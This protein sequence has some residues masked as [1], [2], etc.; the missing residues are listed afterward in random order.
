MKKLQ[1]IQFSEGFS[2]YL[3]IKINTKIIKKN[4]WHKKFMNF[5]VYFE[6]FIVLLN[7]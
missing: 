3:Y 5:L 1:N 7:N 4:K 2:I 6:S